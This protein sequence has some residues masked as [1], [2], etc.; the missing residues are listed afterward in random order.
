MAVRF[1]D[2]IA[3]RSAGTIDGSDVVAIKAG[4]TVK[5]DGD[6]VATVAGVVPARV[7]ALGST[8]SDNTTNIN[9]ALALGG[10]V[11]IP[12]GEW[13]IDDSININVPGSRLIGGG[14]TYF[15][16]TAGISRLIQTT[17]D[18]PIIRIGTGVDGINIESLSL[19]H[20]TQQT[21]SDTDGY[22]IVM[23]GI[24]SQHSYR[25]LFIEKC[26]IGIGIEQTGNSTLFASTLDNV[27]VNTFTITGIDL[28][29]YEGG[30][31]GVVANN[32]YLNAS[33]VTV[34]EAPLR[35]TRGFDYSLTGLH[36]EDYKGRAAIE[37]FNCKGLQLTGT[38][39]ERAVASSTGDGLGFIR[40][41]DS[42]LSN[43]S[44]DGLTIYDSDVLSADVTSYY[45]IHSA[46]AS[47]N[48]CYLT[49]RRITVDATT[50]VTAAT[51]KTLRFDS[52][53]D[54]S[55]AW[56]Q[57]AAMAAG[58][59]GFDAT[60]A[61]LVRQFNQLGSALNI[62]GVTARSSS[63][64]A[65][66]SFQRT[67]LGKSD[68][69]HT[70][71][72]QTGT[73]AITAS[74]YVGGQAV[75]DPGRIGVDLSATMSNFVAFTGLVFRVVDASNFLNVDMSTTAVTLRKYV[76]GTASTLASASLAM[77]SGDVARLR[78]VARGAF[79]QVFADGHRLFTHTLTGGDET[80]YGSATPLGIRTSGAGA[81][82][83][84]VV[85]MA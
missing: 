23:T 31:T 9:A 46:Q 12:E 15:G 64:I 45:V 80:T 43:V 58:T 38:H 29:N 16:A 62:P 49:A 5:V 60:P 7:P 28:R 37:L 21:S 40:V 42:V 8:A 18:T 14:V 19:V 70:W 54:S 67:A 32:I 39:L 56:V 84:F 44:I 53:S 52:A 33:G 79:I 11:V 68:S 63:V 66:D 47:T 35:V 81:M 1:S 2:F 59:L 83:D 82:S 61:R 30:G 50:T 69:G 3:A 13:E 36:C 4:A 34:A 76:A 73:P 57:N 65:W 77:A 17:G 41:L 10:T 20:E 71:T 85:A 6:D 74:A 24:C 25:N 75:I 22:G 27:R 72:A 26:S 78:I 48:V 55:A 51:F